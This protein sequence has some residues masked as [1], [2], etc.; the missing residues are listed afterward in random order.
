MRTKTI[1]DCR[2]AEKIKPVNEVWFASYGVAKAAGYVS[3]GVCKPP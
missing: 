2:W 1:S 3:C